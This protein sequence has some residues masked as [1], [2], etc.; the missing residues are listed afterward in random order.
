MSI[1]GV[2]TAIFAP[3]AE[4][5]YVVFA[6]FGGSIAG[7]I[8][9]GSMIALEFSTPERRPTYIGLNSTANGITSGIAPIIGGFLA[10]LLGFK[11]MFTITAA[12]GVIGFILLHWWVQEPRKAAAF[13][14]LKSAE[15]TE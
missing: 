7:S 11:S 10:G 5:F 4:W 9:S 13:D 14:R 6:L 3:A 12:F 2:T 15:L 8:L 1:A